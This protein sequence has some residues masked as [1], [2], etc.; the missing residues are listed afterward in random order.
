MDWGFF[1][2][3]LGLVI[4]WFMV[5]FIVGEDITRAK[6]AKEEL[7]K[8]MKRFEYYNSMCEK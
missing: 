6:I 4:T 2:L 5:G 1:L 3:C 7:E 8:E